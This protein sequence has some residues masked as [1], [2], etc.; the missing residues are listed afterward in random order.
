MIQAMLGEMQE[1]LLA[2]QM[3]QKMKLDT[4][5]QVV[6]TANHELNEQFDHSAQMGQ[7]S[8]A[9]AQLSQ[10][11]AA[12]IAALPNAASPAANNQPM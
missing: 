11:V 6:D 3:N 2:S 1:G 12:I 10:S 8:A 9:L 4:V 5:R 7:V